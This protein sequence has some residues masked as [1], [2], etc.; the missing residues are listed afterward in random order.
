MST[1]SFFSSSLSEERPVAVLWGTEL[2][3]LGCFGG[4]RRQERLWGGRWLCP[5]APGVGVHEGCF[6]LSHGVCSQESLPFAFK[7]CAAWAAHVSTDDA[8]FPQAA[9]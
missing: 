5:A 8:V 9:S 1:S 7:A 6:P 2:H 3:A 4:T